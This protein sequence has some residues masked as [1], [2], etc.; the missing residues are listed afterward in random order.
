MTTPQTPINS[1]FGQNSTAMEVIAG[2]DLSGKTALVTGGYSG[3]GTA[4]VKAL[5]SAGARVIV[6][7]RRPEE[8]D[9]ALGADRPRVDVVVLDLADPA[10][11][12]ACAA[13][14]AALTPRL[15]LLINNAGILGCPLSRDTRGYES[16]FA[17]NHLGHFQLAAR[18]WPL[19]RA[20]G[21]GAR[22]VALS[23]LSHTDSAFHPEDPHYY[24]RDYEKWE[25]YGQAKTANALFAV[26]LDRLAA[27][28][29]IRAFSVHPGSIQ[30]N[31]GRYLSQQDIAALMARLAEE[32]AAGGPAITWKSAE[33]G[34]ATTIWAATSPQLAGKGGVYCVDCDIADLLAP[35][36]KSATGVMA[37]ACDAAMAETLWAESEK[38]I[39]I[40]FNP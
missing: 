3:I 11:V 21:T 28:Y 33:A 9:V 1:G 7:G 29:G 19:I 38:M 39:G 32:V 8:A 22:V 6:A 25:A 2:V 17:T 20:A 5:L 16:Q 4:T 27:P 13:Q 10:S 36:E 40:S 12:D 24:N 26:H 23:S 35:G 31:L 18:L 14:V 34:A 30:T 37:H 15:D